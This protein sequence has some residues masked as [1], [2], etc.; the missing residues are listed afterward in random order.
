MEN[1]GR[2][3]RVKVP[4]STANLGP[5]FD[6]LG[7]ALDL[8]ATIEMSIADE[9]RIHL[10][11]EQLKKLPT[12]KTN[13]IYQ[14]AQRVFDRVGVSYPELEIA[15]VSDVPIKRGLG[16]SALAIV[17]GLSAANALI[18]NPLSKEELFQMATEWESHPDNVG[19]SLFGGLIVSFWDGNHAK[20]VR[21]EPDPQLEVLIAIPHFELSTE[22][23]R[24]VLPTQYSREEAVMNMGYSSV[25]VAALC[26]GRLDLIKHAMKDTLHQ[27]YRIPLIPGL[28]KILKEATDYGTLGVALSGAGPTILALVD[29]KSKQKTELEQFMWCTLKQAGIESTTIWLNPDMQGVQV[30]EI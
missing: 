17:G 16:S 5:G 29:K 19:A 11:G 18:G 28:D 14:V 10:H 23:A 15:M 2:K 27:P 3:V 4:A 26:T 21:I 12:D 25:L 1:R 20:Y 22:K 13:L 7:L 24:N 8:Y 6:T 9:T 30:Q